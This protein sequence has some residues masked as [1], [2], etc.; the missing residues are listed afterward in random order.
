MRGLRG[1]VVRGERQASSDA[2]GRVRRDQFYARKDASKHRAGGPRP[3]CALRKDRAGGPRRERLKSHG[4]FHSIQKRKDVCQAHARQLY[5][6]DD[7]AN[8]G[9]GCLRGVRARRRLDGARFS[10]VDGL[11][12]REARP[13]GLRRRGR[14][15][16][17]RRR[18][19]LAR[20]ARRAVARARVAARLVC[21][22]ARRGERFGRSPAVLAHAAALEAPP[23]R[24][25]ARVARQALRPRW[26]AAHRGA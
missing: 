24:L 4:V 23:P 18:S 2:R 10:R 20:P 6:D 21:K 15:R 25:H 11:H 22:S 19:L 17:L 9:D 13:Q 16:R 12:A 3:A 7:L 14:R 1:A 26:A 8:R 5:A